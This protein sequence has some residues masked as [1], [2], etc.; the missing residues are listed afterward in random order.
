MI[1][2]LLSLC[3]KAALRGSSKEFEDGK[4]IAFPIISSF[5]W[6]SGR[7]WQNL[8][9]PNTRYFELSTV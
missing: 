4:T 7:V 5:Y 3:W 2:L 6:K 9:V 8:S 1:A